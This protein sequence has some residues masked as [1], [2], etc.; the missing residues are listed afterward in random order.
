MDSDDVAR[1]EHGN[2]PPNAVGVYMA[3]QPRKSVA[4]GVQNVA[5]LFAL[6]IRQVSQSLVIGRMQLGQRR[7]GRFNIVR[8]HLD[9]CLKLTKPG[10]LWFVLFPLTKSSPVA[11][12]L[13]F[14]SWWP[15]LT[16]GCS[17]FGNGDGVGSDARGAITAS[18]SRKC[19]MLWRAAV[20]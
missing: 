4:Q 16:L 5:R 18:S 14:A 17:G 15:M 10:R 20:A 2:H 13:I 11:P 12:V 6:P 3:R 7:A 9:S 19:L 8:N 1:N